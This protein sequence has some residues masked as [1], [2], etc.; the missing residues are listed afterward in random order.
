MKF[1]FGVLTG[2][3]ISFIVNSMN[4]PTV[5]EPV[6]GMVVRSRL[7][8]NHIKYCYTLVEING[9]TL[10]VLDFNLKRYKGD[11]VILKV[12]NKGEYYLPFD[13]ENL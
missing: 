6:R 7:F 4:S 1:T 8:E 10:E 2:L 9:D 5:R 3:A 12:S 13:K 11:T